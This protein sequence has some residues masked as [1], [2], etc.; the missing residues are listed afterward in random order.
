MANVK[1]CD[2]CGDVILSQNRKIVR[3]LDLSDG[4]QA[5]MARTDRAYDMHEK[6]VKELTSWITEQFNFNT[7]EVNK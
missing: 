2:L 3:V 1:V 4:K 7:Q 5:N 6:C